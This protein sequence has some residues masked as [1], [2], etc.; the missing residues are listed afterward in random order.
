MVAAVV[1]AVLSDVGVSAGVQDANDARVSGSTDSGFCRYR[2]YS[3]ST[4]PAFTPENWSNFIPVLS[5]PG[6]GTRYGHRMIR[7]I[8]IDVDGTLL[9]SEGKMPEANRQ[10]IVDAV[11]AGIHVAL[12]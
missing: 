5:Y 1:G 9:D 8:G 2:S 12:V 4:Y 11:D 10:A 7:L 3:S 6:L